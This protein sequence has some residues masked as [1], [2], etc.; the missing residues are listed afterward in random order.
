MQEITSMLGTVNGTILYRKA[1]VGSDIDTFLDLGVPVG[2]PYLIPNDYFWY[3]HSDGDWVDV[4]KTEDLDQNL[5]IFASTIYILADLNE[6]LPKTVIKEKI[7][8][9][10]QP[11]GAFQSGSVLVTS[12]LSFVFLSTFI[13]F[14]NHM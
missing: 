5:A 13:T 4:L 12:L 10:D 2:G 6:P 8:P 11:V 7:T 1:N 14:F 3:H 9:K